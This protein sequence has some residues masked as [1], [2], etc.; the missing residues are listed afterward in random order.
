MHCGRLPGA[1]LRDGI[2]PMIVRA[3][4]RDL[5]GHASA[6]TLGASTTAVDETPTMSV[7]QQGLVDP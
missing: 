4:C 2:Q 6:R 3:A 7:L 1:A 5:L